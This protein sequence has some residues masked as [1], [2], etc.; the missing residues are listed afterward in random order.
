[1]IVIHD[2]YDTFVFMEPH[3]VIGKVPDFTR[4]TM[5]KTLGSYLVESCR[6]IFQV[7]LIGVVVEAVEDYKI[8][9]LDVFKLDLSTMSWVKVE[10]LGDRI[11]LLGQSSTSISATEVG[12]EGNCIYFCPPKS[13]S[14]CKFDMDD[15]TITTTIHGPKKFRYWS[16]PLWMVP[17][18]VPDCRL[19]VKKD[20]TKIEDSKG[21]GNQEISWKDL[22]RELLGLILSSLSFGDCIRIRLTCESWMSITPPL[23]SNNLHIPPESGHLV[24]WLMCFP[25]KNHSVYKI[26]HPIYSGG[27]TN[28][29]PELAGAIIRNARCGWLLISRG[30]TCIFFFNPFTLEIINLPDFDEKEDLKNMSFSNP[31]TSSDFIVIGLSSFVMLVYRKSEN[32]WRRYFL[33]LPYEVT[34]SACNPVFYEGIFYFLCKDGKLGLF[35]PDVIKENQMLVFRNSNFFSTSSTEPDSMKSIGSYIVECDGAIL[36]VFVGRRGK[37]VSVFKLDKSRMKWNR[38]E[39][40]GDN[41]LFL[42][43]TASALIPAPL[44]GIENRIYF[45]R[46]QGED[47]VFYSLS[48]CKYHWF[49]CKNSGVEDWLNT[50]GHMDCTWIQ[51]TN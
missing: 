40:L 9:T 42:S 34:L 28:N 26:Y 37:P 7:C 49:G 11:F 39:T 32:T 24:P 38:L 14:L 44:K 20:T 31:P 4:S 47:N 13:T 27:Y 3:D 10:S 2:I 48:T 18:A 33:G 23:R 30:D 15:G 1:M 21:E 8:E 22:P 51:S 5:L 43:H 46:F 50:S 19:Q 16:G 12:L 45:P 29:I 17:V 41:V 25:K 36:S 35:N 6:E